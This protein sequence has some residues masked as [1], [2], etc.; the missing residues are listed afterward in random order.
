MEQTVQDKLIDKAIDSIVELLESNK[1]KFLSY[2]E[3]SGEATK[4]L[5]REIAHEAISTLIRGDVVG[6]EVE[7]NFDGWGGITE[8][9]IPITQ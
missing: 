4:A 9:K 7:A 8:L 5:A 6:I 1:G 2:E 3:V